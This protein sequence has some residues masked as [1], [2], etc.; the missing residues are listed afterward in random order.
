MRGGVVTIRIDFEDIL[1]ILD[2]DRV[3]TEHRLKPREEGWV[4][5]PEH[6]AAL[7]EKTLGVERR[8]LAKYEEVATWN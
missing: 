1:T 3:L 4:V 5:V 8:P 7:W 6:H 2:G